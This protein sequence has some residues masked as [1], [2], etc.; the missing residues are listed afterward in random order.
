MDSIIRIVSDEPN[1]E[2]WKNI[3]DKSVHWIHLEAMQEF[4]GADLPIALEL[5]RFLRAHP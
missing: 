2:V 5:G 4:Q 1:I 3:R